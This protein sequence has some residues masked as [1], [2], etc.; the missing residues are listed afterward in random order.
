ST[1]AQPLPASRD[2]IE[3]AGPITLRATKDGDALAYATTAGQH[4]YLNPTLVLR[5]DSAFKATL[6][7]ALD[8]PTVTH[9]HGLSVDTRN[10]GNGETLVAPGERFDYAFPVRNR[11]ALYWYHPHP[12]GATARQIYR[13]L[14]GLIEI[15][16]DEE[17]ALRNAL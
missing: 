7:N 13:G 4:T 9:W 14:F 15:E 8:E 1:F 10:D 6:V 3:V 16:D 2:R 11:A 12:H 5:R 17:I